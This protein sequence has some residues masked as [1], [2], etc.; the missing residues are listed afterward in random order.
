MALAPPAFQFYA[1]DFLVS[2]TTFSNEEVGAYIRLLSHQWVNGSVPDDLRALAQI[3]H[4]SSCVTQRIWQKISPKFSRGTD[5]L[6]R[7]PRLEEVRQKHYEFIELQAAKPHK[8]WSKPYAAAMPRHMPDA[9]SSI[10][11]LQS[12][13]KN[14]QG[15]KALP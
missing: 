3:L 4:T 1:G 12:T 2:T 8:R 13:Y 9:C 14:A 15:A 10:S 7:N 6:L 5:K 11:D